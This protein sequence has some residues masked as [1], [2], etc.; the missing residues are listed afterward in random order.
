MKLLHDS[1]K[2]SFSQQI[3]N[4]YFEGINMTDRVRILLS[5]QHHVISFNI[6]KKELKELIDN[7]SELERGLK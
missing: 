7:L 1:K 3:D 2:F 5:Q 6:T 4:M